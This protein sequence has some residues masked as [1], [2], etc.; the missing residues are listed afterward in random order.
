MNDN[1]YTITIYGPVDPCTAYGP[2]DPI[3][4]F[5]GVGEQIWYPGQINTFSQIVVEAIKPT[6]VW[7]GKNKLIHL[8]LRSAID[9]LEKI[10]EML[11]DEPEKK[12]ETK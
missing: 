10:D 4:P 6:L 9:M 12:E 11:A 5:P 1:D 8:F 3:T 2:I 7:S